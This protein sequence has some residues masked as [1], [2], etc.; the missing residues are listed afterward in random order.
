MIRLENSTAKPAIQGSNHSI[1]KPIIPESRDSTT[2]PATQESKSHSD[3]DMKQDENKNKN[4]NSRKASNRNDKKRGNRKRRNSA[5]ARNPSDEHRP[6]NRP[7]SSQG[8][9]LLP[10]PGVNADAPIGLGLRI[11][12]YSDKQERRTSDDSDNRG[13]W[14]PQ[15][16]QQNG[17]VFM[18]RPNFEGRGRAPRPF[19]PNFQQQLAPMHRGGQGMRF[20][21]LPFVQQFQNRPDFQQ[22]PGQRPHFDHALKQDFQQRPPFE[23][24]QNQGPRM[25]ASNFIP[26]GFKVWKCIFLLFDGYDNLILCS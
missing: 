4:A 2:K 1:A 18:S 11:P 25:Q 12:R 21:R 8:I 5:E 17:D 10:T 6:N 22:R 24:A 26:N 15:Q 14:R 13:R 23:H 16:Q 9:G 7:N 19:R 20:M 3:G